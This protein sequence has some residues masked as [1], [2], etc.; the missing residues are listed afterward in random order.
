MRRVTTATVFTV[1]L[2]SFS[3]LLLPA[4]S[5]VNN[6]AASSHVSAQAKVNRITFS[7]TKPFSQ[8][9]ANQL[10]IDFQQVST[11]YNLV[12]NDRF[13]FWASSLAFSPDGHALA[14]GGRYEVKGQPATEN[15]ARLWNLTYNRQENLTVNINPR[16]FNGYAGVV[17][18]VEF[19]PDGRT[20]ATGSYDATIK[21]WNLQLSDAQPRVLTGHKKEIYTVVFSPNGQI[22]ASAG[23]DQQIFL[24]NPATGAL[25]DRLTETADINSIAISP[26]SQ[27]LA[28]GSKDKTIKLWDLTTGKLLRTLAGHS[29]EV[30]AVAFSPDGRTLASGS[31]DKTVKLWNVKDGKLL[32]TLIKHSDK[33][34]AVAFSPDGRTLASGSEDTTINLWNVFDGE[35]RHTRGKH[36]AAV[37]SISFN[38]VGPYFVSGGNDGKVKLWTY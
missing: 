38:P 9:P 16:I 27:I 26:N 1:L 5:H 2:A 19:S 8:R 35:L 29:G 4:R 13:S 6:F 34:N 24:W 18:S 33:V 11:V 32:H 23:K 37:Y 28:S 30:N 7:P 31:D 22:L 20:L 15:G 25:R 3:T 21:L 36:T 10:A 12:L 17:R 14:G